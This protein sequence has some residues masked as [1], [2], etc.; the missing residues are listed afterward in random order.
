MGM[1][2]HQKLKIMAKRNRRFDH[3]FLSG[4]ILFATVLVRVLGAKI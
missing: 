1:R 3:I 4:N 2:E